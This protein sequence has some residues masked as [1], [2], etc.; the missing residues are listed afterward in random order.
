MK[1]LKLA[2]FNALASNARLVAMV[3]NPLAISSAWP[4]SDVGYSDVP[5]NIDDY[6]A[7]APVEVP[8][9]RITFV[10]ISPLKD[11][12]LPTRD[13]TFQIDVWS[14][15]AEL[16]EA[17]VTELETALDQDAARRAGR[18]LPVLAI[19]SG[20]ITETYCTRGPDL[21]EFDT[22]IFHTPTNLRVLW[23]P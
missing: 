9:A 14:P 18:A 17:I 2:I 21:Y 11:I 19:P 4:A 6:T 20:R 23:N 15:S 7:L 12:D 5:A 10:L 3:G 16:T 22:R 8:R 1:R 13:D